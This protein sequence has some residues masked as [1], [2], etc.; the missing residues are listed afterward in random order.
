ML[1]DELINR[2]NMLE[3]LISQIE[4]EKDLMPDGKM[5]SCGGS[6]GKFYRVDE[7]G[8]RGY[9]PSSDA[10]TIS[11]YAQKEYDEA[12]FDICR[13]ELYHINALLKSEKKDELTGV[14]KRINTNKRKWI[15]RRLLTDNEF[16]KKWESEEYQGKGFEIDDKEFYTDRGERVRSKSEKIIADSFFHG[17][18]P[19]KYECPTMIGNRMV[20]TDFKVLN[21]RKRKEYKLEHFG[22]MD[23]PEYANAAVKKI[24]AYLREGYMVGKDL[25][26]LFESSNVPLSSFM[27]RTLIETYLI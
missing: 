21:V 15:K 10:K 11:L 2:K 26:L 3:K 20:Y 25:L 13:K 7:N 27:I 17:D 5:W 8:N 1:I 12:V 24:N 23:N 6:K 19:Y 16:R 18:I 22:M 4:S 14:I 9:I